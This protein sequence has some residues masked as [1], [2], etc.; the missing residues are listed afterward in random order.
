ML[1]DFA[2]MH[3]N[4]GGRFVPGRMYL[5]MDSRLIAAAATEPSAGMFLPY[6]PN[7]SRRGE[8]RWVLSERQAVPAAHCK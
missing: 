7:G 4:A 5:L 8:M 6:P 2:V 3:L 1:S